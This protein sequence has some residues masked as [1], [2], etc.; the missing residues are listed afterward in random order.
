M[1]A[2]HLISIGQNTIKS[3]GRVKPRL[4]EPVKKMRLIQ[5]GFGSEVQRS[6]E[7]HERGD[8]GGP[9]SLQGQLC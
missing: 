1:D 9:R 7:D 8:E 2:Q 3:S 6:T 4:S 5:Q